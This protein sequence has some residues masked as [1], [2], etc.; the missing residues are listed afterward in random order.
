MFTLP[1]DVDARM[2]AMQLFDQFQHEITQRFE[3]IPNYE[4][5]NESDPEAS[6]SV[7]DG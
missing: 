7:L 4:N 6:D 5:E 1:K 3:L 2:R